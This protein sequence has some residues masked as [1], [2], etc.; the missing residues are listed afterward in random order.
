MKIV[1][2]EHLQVAESRMLSILVKLKDPELL[3]I[4]VRYVG[5]VRIGLMLNFAGFF[6]DEFQLFAEFSF[7]SV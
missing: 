6:I 1:E 3:C 4:N 2:K 7:I 5:Y